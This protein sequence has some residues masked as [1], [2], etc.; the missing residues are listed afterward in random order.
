MKKTSSASITSIIIVLLSTL[1][2]VQCSKAGDGQIKAPG[3]VDGDIITLKARVNGNIV[4]MDLKEG[5]A[6]EKDKSVV[7]IDSDKIHNQIKELDIRT[8]EIWVNREKIANNLRFLKANIQYLDKQVKRFKRLKEKKALPGE[9]FESMQ[10]KLLRT[11]TSRV[12]LQKTLTE[13]DLQEEKI[14]NKREY[15]ELL[16]DDH[17]IS[18]PVDGLVLETFVSRGETLFPGTA[19]ADILDR[20]SLFIEVF[21][22]EREMAALKLNQQVDI[23]VDGIDTPVKGFISFFGKKAEFSPKYIISETERKALLYQV[24]VRV[25]ENEDN[26]ILKVGMPVTVVLGARPEKN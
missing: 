12:E 19:V 5:Q 18:S 17:T 2:F 7:R 22:E 11:Q 14:A 4:E 13:L 26:G 24:K 8:R 10:L 1:F 23:L 21:I 16:L 25:K 20:S 15:L 6:L 9:K 3:I